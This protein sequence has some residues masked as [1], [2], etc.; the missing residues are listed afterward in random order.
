[1]TLA[2]A[3]FLAVLALATL[4]GVV[5]VMLLAVIGRLEPIRTAMG[6]GAL[7]LPLRSR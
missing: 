3:T 5:L 4:A 7:W 1:M 2:V 6:R